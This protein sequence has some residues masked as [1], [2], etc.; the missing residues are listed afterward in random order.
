[1]SISELFGVY[2]AFEENVQYLWNVYVIFV[3]ASVGWLLSLK[4][5]PQR[6]LKILASLGFLVVSGFDIYALTNNYEMLWA[7]QTDLKTAMLNATS[8]G[9][10]L[11]DKIIAL[12]SNL[13]YQFV[14]YSLHLAGATIVLTALWSRYVFEHIKSS[15]DEQ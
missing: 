15:P 11:R 1:M 7:A 5:P 14:V 12:P 9:E 8:Q 10:H 4:H 3:I 13:Y 6:N 2:F